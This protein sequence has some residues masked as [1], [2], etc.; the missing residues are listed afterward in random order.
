[1]WQG[2]ILPVT[3]NQDFF[4]ISIM[5]AA[6]CNTIPLLPKRLTYPELFPLDRYGDYFYDEGNLTET[7]GRAMDTFQDMDR[8]S[9]REEAGRYDWKN[10]IS[11]YD[12]F[13][14]KARNEAQGRAPGG[15]GKLF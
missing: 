2:D 8:V 5:E 15:Y 10:M 13:F 12:E 3:S 1:M 4:G 9:I 6:Y 14:E 11:V 7:L